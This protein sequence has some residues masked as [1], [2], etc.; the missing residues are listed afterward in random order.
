MKSIGTYCRFYAC[1]TIFWRFAKL[2]SLYDH[3]INNHKKGLPYMRIFTLLVA[4]LFFTSFRPVGISTL[5]S[6]FIPANNVRIPIDA[7]EVSSVTEQDVKE[8]IDVLYGMYK[9]TFTKLN[10]SLHFNLQWNEDQFNAYT[11]LYRGRAQVVI[12]GGMIRHPLI[13]KDGIA[14]VLCHEIGHHLA[15]KPKHRMYWVFPMFASAEGQADYFA[16]LKCLRTYFRLMPQEQERVDLPDEVVARCE[17][18]FAD[19]IKRDSCIRSNMAGLTMANVLNSLKKEPLP[20]LGF[21]NP[22]QTEVRRT[23]R[24]HPNPQCRLDTYYAGTLC[25]VDKDTPIDINKDGTGQC[26]RAR[27]DLVG[28][29]P[30]CWYKLSKSL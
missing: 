17:D 25:Q 30:R 27:G 9:D 10:R 1:A 7:K 13:S 15:G 16:T 12:T 20:N 24:K 11:N 2:L 28:V 18:Q 22:D 3:F 8:V 19:N 5:C 26:T 4:L 14:L 23:F 21:I 6:G 29:R